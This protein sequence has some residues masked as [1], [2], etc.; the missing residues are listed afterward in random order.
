MFGFQ[1]KVFPSVHDRVG[2]DFGNA[3]LDPLLEFGPGGN[4]DMSEKCSIHLG[5]EGFHRVEPRPV[6]RRMD[7][8]ESVGTSGQVDPGFLGDIGRMVVQN[9][10]DPGMGRIAGVQVLEKGDE[11]LAPMP[12][13]YPGDDMAGGEIQ[14][15][16]DRGRSQMVKVLQSGLP[17]HGQS[18]VDA[19]ID[20]GTANPH[21]SGNGL[22]RKTIRI[23]QKDAGS[24]RFPN[25]GRSGSGHGL[26]VLS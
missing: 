17:S 1:V 22:Q 15:G 20:S 13:L 6:L 23:G 2:V 12:L 10:P 18:F 3:L 9:D 14:G 25:R 21:L 4:T 16:Q 24:L 7:I 26:E 5:E 19:L 11:F 8:L